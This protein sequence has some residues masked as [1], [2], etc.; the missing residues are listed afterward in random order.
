MKRWC[1]CALQI[2]ILTL[3]ALPEPAQCSIDA[4]PPVRQRQYRSESVEYV[5]E[6]V[7]ELLGDELGQLFANCF[8]NTLDKTVLHS[9]PVKPNVWDTFIITGDIPAMWL[10][11]SMNQVLPYVRIINAAR[12]AN[13]TDDKLVNFLFGVVHRLAASIRVDPFANAFTWNDDGPQGRGLS[14]THLGDKTFKNINGSQFNAM[15]NALIF[16]R[17]FEVDSLLSLLK[18]TTRLAEAVGEAETIS[19]FRADDSIVPALSD[20]LFVLK[21]MQSC[22]EST[23]TFQRQSSEPTDTRSHGTG[24]PCRTTGLIRSA[25]RASDDSTLLEFN[26]PENAMAAVELESLVPL[27]D[28]LAEAFEKEQH[29]HAAELRS[30]ASRAGNL[31]SLL[32]AAIRKHGITV[33]RG[34]EVLAYEVDGFGNAIFMDD[35]NIPSLLSLPYLGFCSSEDALYKR[36]RQ[37]VLSDGNPWFFSGSAG[38]PGVGG[39]HIGKSYIWP[40]AIMAA[41]FTTKNLSELASIFKQLQVTAQS[42]GLMRESFHM[43]NVNDF[44]RPWF[45]WANQLFGD[46]VLHVATSPELCGALGLKQPLDLVALMQ[47]FPDQP[48]PQAREGKKERK[49]P[50]DTRSHQLRKQRWPIRL[51]IDLE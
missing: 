48:S 1:A 38:I 32:R 21:V 19:R 29:P 41:G 13:K 14:F 33:F 22:N 44:T 42:N 23:Y 9:A 28:T 51:K 6:H 27:A 35:A 46:L 17:K 15:N 39:P 16:E 18:L 24:F 3:V 20:V 50:M 31:A 7:K 8:T 47:K 34:Q 25:F 30:I 12:I 2:L 11:D 4:R 10:R 43:D 36:T 40:M 26:I 5:V 45:A 37:M 49:P